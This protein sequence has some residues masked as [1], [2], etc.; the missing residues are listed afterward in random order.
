VTGLDESSGLDTVEL[1][2]GDVH[3]DDVGRELLGH[4]DRFG[5]GG[6]LAHHL[7]AVFGHRPAEPLAQHAMV[8]C[9]HQSDGHVVSLAEKIYVWAR[10]QRT[11]VPFRGSDSTS[12]VAPMLAARSRIPRMPNESRRPAVPTGK[13]CPSSA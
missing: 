4:G 3:E 8:V 5:T 6:G 13:P 9:Q 7:E 1:G 2:H 10:Y 11:R 12:R